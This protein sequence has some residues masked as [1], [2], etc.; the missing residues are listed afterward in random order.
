MESESWSAESWDQLIGSALWYLSIEFC[1]S[2]N[3]PSRPFFP[4]GGDLAVDQCVG[5]FVRSDAGRTGLSVESLV[6]D[7][8]PAFL[9]VGLS[10]TILPYPFFLSSS[11]PAKGKVVSCNQGNHY[12]QGLFRVL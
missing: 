8:Q 2:C 7:R 6:A 12:Y 11:V 1:L 4:T 5:S 10:A 3:P 9:P